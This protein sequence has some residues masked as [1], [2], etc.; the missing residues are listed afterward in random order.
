MKFLRAYLGSDGQPIA[1]IETDRP[2]IDAC[3]RDAAGVPYPF[4][5]LG[6]AEPAA[7]TSVA[8]EPAPASQHFFERIEKHPAADSHTD[9][10]KVRIKPAHVAECPTVHFCPAG[11]KEIED[12]LATRPR[13]GLPTAAQALLRGIWRHRE[14]ISLKTLQ[15][16]GMT[17]EELKKLPRIERA[18]QRAADAVAAQR[19]QELGERIAGERAAKW[20]AKAALKANRKDDNGQPL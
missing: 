19:A 9:A 5:D 3:L 14:D 12:H 1:V 7:W 4:V 2:I 17:A 13:D 6:V 15:G 8:G 10:P 11:Q 18:R 20:A 16:L